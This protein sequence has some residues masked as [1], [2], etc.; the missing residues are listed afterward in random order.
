MQE[1]L[2]MLCICYNIEMIEKDNFRLSDP[3]RLIFDE[4][5]A[6]VARVS[7]VTDGYDPTPRDGAV[8]LGTESGTL[9]LGHIAFQGDFD[10]GV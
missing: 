6:R 10:S 3:E 1:V 5:E 8:E 4:I 9:P 2:I 7:E